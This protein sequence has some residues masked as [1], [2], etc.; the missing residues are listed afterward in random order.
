[1]NQHLVRRLTP[2]ERELEKKHAELATLEGELAE[3]ELEF[4][5]LQNELRAFEALYLRIVGALY[6][7]LD[8]LEAQIAEG[9]ARRHPQ[10]HSLGEEAAQARAKATESAHA[11]NAVPET[12]EDRFKPGDA[13]RKLYRDIARQIHPDLATDDRNRARRTR[14]MAEA[15]K[16]YAAGDEAKLTAILDEWHSSP[17][18]VEGEG[19][20]SELVR[21]IRKIHQVERRLAEI[22]VSMTELRESAL[23]R[24]REDVTAAEARGRDL[25]A[26]MAEQLRRDIAAARTR[27]T[28]LSSPEAVV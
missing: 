11:I 14:L 22:G 25:L 4:A 2:E 8:D 12:A 1:M 26:D 7:E 9:Q 10:E 16:A 3:R 23:H 27:L 20:A 17:E 6:A 19:I 5:T 21:T 18:A 24:L 15:N 13:L 28:R